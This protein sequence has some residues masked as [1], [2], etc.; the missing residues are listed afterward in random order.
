MHVVPVVQQQRRVH[1]GDAD[2][3]HLRAGSGAVD[4]DSPSIWTFGH[5]ALERGQIS[6]TK[7]F[8]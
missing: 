1:R 3:R 6:R 5:P 4:F 7:N 2:L 8:F